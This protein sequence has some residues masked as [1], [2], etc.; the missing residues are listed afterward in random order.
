[1]VQ[2]TRHIV[3]LMA[4]L[5]MVACGTARQQVVVPEDPPVARAEPVSEKD[6]LQSTALLIEGIQQK[7]LGNLERAIVSFDD[8]IAKDPNNDAAYFEL[9]RV[10]ATMHAFE[11]ALHSAN[12]AIGLDPDNKQYRLLLADIHVLQDDISKAIG[13]YEQLALDNPDNPDIQ[14][15]LVSAYL[16]DDRFDEAIRVLEYIETLVGFS[17]DVSIQKQKIWVN[18]GEFEK[19]IQEAEQMIRFYPEE[20]MFYE[21]L[22]DLYMETGRMDKARDIYQEILAIEPDSHLA[23]LLLA[24]YYHEQNQPDSAFVFLKEAFRNQDMEMD[25]KGRIIFSYMHWSEEDPAFLEQALELTEILLDVHPD[26]PESYLIKGDLLV[27]GGQNEQARDMYL[28]GARMDPSSL[29]VWQ[30]I[31]SLDLQLGDFEGMREHSDEALEYFI[32]QPIIFLFNGLAHMQLKDY[33]SAASSLEYGLVLAVADED[34]QQDFLTMLGD[35]YFYLDA[36]E[37]SDK[38]YEKA[39]ERNP[40][41]A[42]ALN[43]YSY[44][45]ALRKERLDEALEM[46]EESLRLQPDNAA[47]MDTYGWIHYQLGNYRKAEEWIS[48]ALEYSDPASAAILEHYGD[49]LYK[50]EE[51]EQAL[52]YWEKALES[53]NGSDFLHKKIQDRT[54]YE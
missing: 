19:A 35:T 20:I 27:R 10:H 48:R 39:L 22:G 23:R 53:G 12:K 52:I 40:A 21:L 33:Q 32:E 17:K 30:Q 18:Q 3:F 28:R 13:V 38:Y 31:L 45:L 2:Q 1:M 37:E 4:A 26:D 15:T 49:V 50:L 14:K 47:F 36:H 16:V 34:L 7:N 54:L 6:Q 46:S 29:S 44:H 9:S 43:N 51:K 25:G 41:N 8:A 5:L 24:D 11:D 42:T